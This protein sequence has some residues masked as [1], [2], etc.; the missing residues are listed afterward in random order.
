[1]GIALT[2]HNP[3]MKVKGRKKI[4]IELLGKMNMLCREKFQ[5]PIKHVDT[6]FFVDEVLWVMRYGPRI[7]LLQFRMPDRLR[8][9]AKSLSSRL[10]EYGLQIIANLVAVV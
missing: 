9:G 7:I 2:S 8:G 3:S 6:K 4:F 5:V 1:L 10:P